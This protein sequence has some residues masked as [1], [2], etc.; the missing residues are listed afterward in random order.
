MRR[1]AL[2]AVMV[3]VLGSAPAAAEEIWSATLE[4]GSTD[5]AGQTQVGYWNYLTGTLGN[6]V[7]S[8]NFHQ[9]GKEFTFYYILVGSPGPGDLS[10]QIAPIPDINGW[11]FTFGDRR[12]SA[13]D[14]QAGYY[15]RGDES[16]HNVALTWQGA[17]LSW[18]EG[19]RIA[20]TLE[21]PTSVAVLPAWGAG[22]LAVTLGIGAW[23][24]RRRAP[25]ETV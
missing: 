19:D 11:S 25:S 16:G 18:S 21:R 3:V 10:M 6:L 2:L 1:R 17:D 7:P 20:V 13:S 5:A 14:A 4:A 23:K 12:L 24:R 8:A 9:D 22:V 15:T